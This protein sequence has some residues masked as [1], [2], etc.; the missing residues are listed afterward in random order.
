LRRT[1]LAFALLACAAHAAPPGALT[2]PLRYLQ[3]E[4]YQSSPHRLWEWQ[5][6][7]LSRPGNVWI[8]LGSTEGGEYDAVERGVLNLDLASRVA[9]HVE[10][11]NDRDP[12]GRVARA[13]ADLLVNVAPGVWLGASGVPAARKQD[14]GLGGSVVVADSGRRRFLLA[15]LVADQFLYNRTNTDGGTRAAPVLHAQLQAR[16]EDG[17]WSL[18]GSV[19]AT[20][21]SETTFPG[22]AAVTYRAA[23]RR[24]LSL[25]ARYA[26][27]G[28]ETD[29]RLDLLRVHDAQAQ[30]AGSS[31]LRHSIATLRLDALLPPV[32][33]TGWRPRLGV[34]ALRGD[35]T[36][37]EGGVPYRVSR[38]EP[39]A[40]LGAQRQDGA[41]TWELGYLLAVPLL[42]ESGG[43]GEVRHS[44]YED[45]VYGSS[46]V[47]FGRIHLR[48]LLSWEARHGRFGGANGNVLMQF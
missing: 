7:T 12:E 19:D 48:A 4:T 16:W 38:L 44:A 41:V 35:A 47:S 45:M 26:A 3:E 39:G 11:R 21:E 24:E 28:L 18:A 2:D 14:Y 10:L 43:A 20:T 32:A 13:V 31:A 17:P 46:E 27:G 33:G 15:R 6:G 37:E 40:R 22:E 36:G 29:A 5:E 8:N 42:R 23:S 34:R 9:F 25:H 30:L 1:A